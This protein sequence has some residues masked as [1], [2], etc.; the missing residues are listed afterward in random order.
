MDTVE[1]RKNL[2]YQ[3]LSDFVL[4]NTDRHLNNIGILRDTESLRFV[5]MAPIFD[6]GKSLFVDTA[7]PLEKKDILQIPIN[8]FSKSQIKLL[9]YVTDRALVD[10]ARIMPPE[11][12]K[13][14]YSY[15]SKMDDT[16]ISRVCEGY[17]KKIELFRAYQLGHSLEKIVVPVRHQSI[18]PDDVFEL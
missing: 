8:S 11:T 7:V 9:D 12:I 15:D 1:L 13:K 10:A 17:E 4:N 16:T 2:E 18:V 6:T 5:R 3:I 14:A